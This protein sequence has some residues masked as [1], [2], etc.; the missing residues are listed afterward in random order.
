VT[1]TELS[2]ITGQFA[3]LFPG[4]FCGADNPLD[5]RFVAGWNRLQ[6]FLPVREEIMHRS[7]TTR[8]SFVMLAV[9][10]SSLG[11][12]TARGDQKDAPGPLT[13]E[14]VQAWRDAGAE[15]G[16]M[17]HLPPRESSYRF[18]SPWRETGDA[19]SLPAFRFP[20]RDRLAQL[21][22]PGTPFGLDLHCGFAGRFGPKE[23]S[24]FKNLRALNL[25]GSQRLM[26]ADL[27]ELAGLK[28]LQ[29]LYLF[30]DA[31]TDAGLKELAGMTNLQV[32][33]L[34]ST[35]IT[36]AGLKELAGMTNLQA[37]NLHQTRVTNVG[38][39]E[40]AG[41]KNLRWLNLAHTQVTEAGVAALQ[42]ELPG[43][44]IGR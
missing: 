39:K 38:L 30:Y 26:D 13:P 12:F 33:D 27:K 34:T 4:R 24:G 35:R 19:Q 43:C 16:W 23:L 7:G 1:V 32:L 31:V 8:P 11:V 42:K 20:Q 17:I 21:P 14:V 15:V 37:L 9:L 3:S 36:D 29:A 25:G 5:G 6:H 2:V 44:T 22:D 28:N 41:L 18:W 40:L 10:A